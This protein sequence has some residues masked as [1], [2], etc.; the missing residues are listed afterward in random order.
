MTTET[1]FGID[2]GGTGIKGAPVD[3]AN[4]TVGEPRVEIDT[5]EP[6]TPEAVA[7]AVTELVT[8][9]EQTG[10]IGITLPAVVKQG[11]ARTAANIDHS[12][13]GTDARALFARELGREPASVAILN[14]AD[15][16]GL[17]E[18]RYS[19]PESTAGVTTL[20]TLG[21][22]IGS[23]LFLDG[24]L[25]PNTEFGHLEI[26]GRDAELL[27][28]ASIK[29]DHGLGYP[30]WAERVNRYLTVLE[31]LVSPDR[32]I[33]GGGISKAAD[34]WVPLLRLRG[35]ALV[36]SRQNDAGIVGAALAAAE[37]IDH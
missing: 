15:A 31:N 17:A 3:L 4:G 13:I 29:D 18:V 32:I 2:I 1:G 34:E 23:A 20:I 36:A 21:T 27:A 35:K 14:D 33:L 5:P 30:A 10:P 9:F 19:H 7:K 6:S 8:H 16:A 22:G 11:F 24:R 25:V 28:A 37:G 12:W 26:D